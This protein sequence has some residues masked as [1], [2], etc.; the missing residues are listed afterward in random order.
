MKCNRCIHY[1]V[2][3]GYRNIDIDG[4]SNSCP[5]A[6]ERPQGDLISRSALL[7]D[8]EEER[9]YFHKRGLGGAEHILVHHCLPHIDNATAVEQECYITGAQWNEFM[10]EHK[11]PHGEWF[12]LDEC[13]NEGVYCSN[14]HKKVYRVEYANQKVKSNYCPN[15]GAD[16]R[17]GKE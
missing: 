14:C 4:D 6:E 9:Q 13:S 16:M 11:R 15:C 8:M 5:Y 12:L 7:K 10:E 2:C 3:L 1:N 17:G